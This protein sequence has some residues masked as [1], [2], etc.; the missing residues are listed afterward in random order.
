MLISSTNFLQN[1]VN[2]LGN[3]TKKFSDYLPNCQSNNLFS[4]P[5]SEFDVCDQSSTLDA[6]KSADAY[7]I[8]TMMVNAITDVIVGPLTIR[9]N[10]SFSTG[11]CPKLVKYAKV[12]PIFKANSPLE[13][14][15]YFPISLLPICN[16]IIEKLMYSKVNNFLEKNNIIIKQQFGFQKKKSTTL[17][18]PGITTKL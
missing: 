6:K 1:L 17:A 18:I 16:E 8:P 5:V 9:I 10:E 2:K 11:Y 14:T 4:N 12:I 7:D 15:N 13:E 3:T